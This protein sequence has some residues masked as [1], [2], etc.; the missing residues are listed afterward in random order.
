MNT[1]ENWMQKC[2][3]DCQHPMGLEQRSFFSLGCSSGK[4]TSGGQ[5]VNTRVFVFDF[6]SF[7]F[8]TQ[9][10]VRQ[11]KRTV[12]IIVSKI[13]GLSQFVTCLVL[14]ICPQ[15][16]L[17]IRCLAFKQLYSILYSENGLMIILLNIRSSKMIVNNLR[18]ITVYRIPLTCSAVLSIRVSLFRLLLFAALWS[19][20]WRLRF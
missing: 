16:F 6:A 17:F 11:S 20:R 10:T 9:F 3:L 4:R 5:L 18:S 12:G 14:T 15:W 7:S 2:S 19:F 1:T 13:V 8:L